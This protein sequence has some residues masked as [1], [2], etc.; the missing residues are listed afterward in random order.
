MDDLADWPVLEGTPAEIEIV[1]GC[2]ANQVPHL[3]RGQGETV[4]TQPL[5]NF[6]QARLPTMSRNVCT[7]CNRKR[8]FNPCSGH[9]FHLCLVTEQKME[10]APSRKLHT[11]PDGAGRCERHLQQCQ[12]HRAAEPGGAT[13]RYWPLPGSLPCEGL[14]AMVLEEGAGWCEFRVNPGGGGSHLK[15]EV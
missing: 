9:P 8:Q 4:G 1:L 14:R 15:G 5:T 3:R 2:S 11:S 6:R 12:P 7:A 13:P 10:Q